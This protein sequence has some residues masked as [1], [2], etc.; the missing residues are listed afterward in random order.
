MDD[1]NRPHGSDLR[2][3]RCSISIQ[4]DPVTT[5]TQGRQ[6]LFTDLNLG[7]IVVDCFRYQHKNETVKSLAFVVM[8]DHFHWLF[9]LGADLDLSRVLG[10]V[11]SLS[12]RVINERAGR[13]GEVIWQPGFH[14]HALR[15]EEDVQEVARYIV[16]NPL[17]AGLVKRVGD[18]PLW[19][20]I[21]L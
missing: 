1:K 9:S 18:Y 16:A 8:P 13:S 20:A 15:C 7:R 3:G 11:K 5:V 21:W 10:Q 14:D 4:I 12:S 2:K 17:R 6:P 19:D